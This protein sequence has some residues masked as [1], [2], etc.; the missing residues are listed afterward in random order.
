MSGYGKTLTM[1]NIMSQLSARGIPFI[2]FEP[3][4]TVCRRLKCLKDHSVPHIRQLARELRIYR[5]GSRISP[6]QFNPLCIG[7]GISRNEHIDNR[8]ACFQGAMPM[9][10]SMLG[11]LGEALELLYDEHTDPAKPPTIADLQ[12]ALRT[13]LEAKGY[14]A[15][16]YSNFTAMF[17]VR[18][19]VLGRRSIGQVF[20]SGESTPSLDQLL[21]QRTIIELAGLPQEQACLLTLFLLTAVRERIKTTPWSGQGVR[22]VMLLDEAHNIVGSSTDASP[23]E[24]NADPR[25]FASDFF[26]RML[27]E[28]RSLGVAV[29][30]LD[31]LPSAVAQQVV[32]NTASKVVFRESDRDEREIVG[33]A[34]LF[35]PIE[36][37][38][39]ARLRPGEAFFHTEGYFGPQRIRT[40]HIEAEWNLPEPPLESAI[41]P[42]IQ[43]DDWYREAA[44]ARMTAEL[45]RLKDAMDRFDDKR[46]G[47]VTQVAR[48]LRQHARVP[49]G[50]SPTQ[51]AG[52]FAELVRQARTLRDQLCAAFHEFQRES[53]R[54]LLD[55]EPP[56][57]VIDRHLQTRRDSLVNRFESAIEPAVRACM[58]V[59]YDLIRKCTADPTLRG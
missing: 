53:Y 1:L 14:T 7:D 52:L 26:C 21:N 35:G 11:L 2:V 56:E 41:L 28:M 42:F 27:A 49:V 12:K 20:R 15:D 45:D 5:P 46:A 54:P 50:T 34:M 36:M 24:A 8:L 44:T 59:L 25:A 10:G 40:P 32:K 48:L 39:V 30:I 19:G 51:R 3:A 18:V 23:S 16:V 47:L 31:Q 58:S 6:M 38:E 22:L 29:I 57:G 17:D 4:V 13:V 33:G 55:A 43:S 37:E 9:E